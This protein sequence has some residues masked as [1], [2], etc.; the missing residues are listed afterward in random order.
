MDILLLLQPLDRM[1]TDGRG[2][3][4]ILPDGRAQRALDKTGAYMWTSVRV[5]DFRIFDD[6]P[7][8]AF[9]F[10]QLLDRAEA[11]P[12]ACTPSCMRATGTISAR[13]P[14]CCVSTRP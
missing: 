9:S 11:S 2:D 6:T 7:D 8:G 4:R 10:L 13:P 1:T 5:C 14:T 3:Y 12:A